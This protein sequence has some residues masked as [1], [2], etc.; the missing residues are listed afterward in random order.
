MHGES[1]RPRA[2][3][4]SLA[5]DSSARARLGEEPREPALPAFVGR[6]GCADRGTSWESLEEAWWVLG[7]PGVARSLQRTT[8]RVAILRFGSPAPRRALCCQ[9]GAASE[10]LSPSPPCPP[11]A[12][13]KT[14]TKD[15]VRF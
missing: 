8:S 11:R 12:L 5:L 4:L 7:A 13:S 15:L 2:F 9:R 1:F 14:N 6:L 10:P 3:G